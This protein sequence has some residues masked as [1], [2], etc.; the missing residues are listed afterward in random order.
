MS[1]SH[2]AA[3][4]SIQ[5]RATRECVCVFEHASRCMSMRSLRRCTS[6]ASIPAAPLLSQ[7]VSEC[8]MWDEDISNSFWGCCC[9][10]HTREEDRER[11]GGGGNAPQ[12]LQRDH[13]KL[14]SG[15]AKPLS[16][17]HMD[18]LEF[19]ESCWE[20][21]ACSFTQYLARRS[22]CSAAASDQRHWFIY[23]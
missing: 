23:W 11:G 21:N 4:T 5:R 8:R 1:L 2:F 15:A 6:G 12:V 14:W 7:D 19:T 20:S 10:L 9:C 3:L 17:S 18:S 22:Q 13:Q 16:M